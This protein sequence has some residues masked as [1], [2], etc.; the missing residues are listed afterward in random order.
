MKLT[1]LS[2]AQ[3]ILISL[4][5]A[6]SVAALGTACRNSSPKEAHTRGE[7]IQIPERGDSAWAVLVAIGAFA[8][9]SPGATVEIRG[10]RREGEDHLV[11]FWPTASGFGGN[12]VVR[13]NPDGTTQVMIEQ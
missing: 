6:V 12:G 4:V 3:R 11:T 2:P 13:V 1:H 9:R 7:V 5:I 10:Y 8:A